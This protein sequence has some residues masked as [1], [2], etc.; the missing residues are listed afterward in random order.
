MVDVACSFACRASLTVSD[1]RGRRLGRASGTAR[2]GRARSIRVR[3]NR[4]LRRGE[5]LTTR[6]RARI[7]DGRVDESAGRVR[8]RH[9]GGRI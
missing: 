1:A 6:L 7:G 9:R 8:V 4:R 2:P 5:T 3:L